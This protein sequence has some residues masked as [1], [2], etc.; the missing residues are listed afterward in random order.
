MSRKTRSFLVSLSIT[1]LVALGVFLFWR[2]IYDWWRLRS[3]NPTAEIEAIVKKTDMTDDAKKYFYVAH[4]QITNQSTFNDKCRQGNLQEFSIIL[5]CYISY[6]GIY[7]YRV[8]EKQLDGVIEV[9]SAHEM[10]HAAYERLGSNDKQEVNEMLASAYKKVTDERIRETIEQYRKND[11]NS[12]LNELHS[13]LATEVDNLPSGLESYY[14][15]Y[16]NDRSVIVGISKDYEKEFSTRRNSAEQIQKQLKWLKAQ[17]DEKQSNL[18]SR[19]ASLQSEKQQMDQLLASGQTG[20]Y[21]Q[22]VDGF[23]N[24][25]ERYNELVQEVRTIIDRYNQLVEQYQKLSTEL[26]NLYESI[27][28]RPSKL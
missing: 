8:D 7:V 22:M 5:G 17:I 2:D 12:V 27:D 13:I 20:Q 6:D 18:K 24:S 9:T 21:N 1:V 26:N 11:P 3:Y 10:L 16:F 15:K 25:V 23:N 19:Q 28:S 14:K 4:P